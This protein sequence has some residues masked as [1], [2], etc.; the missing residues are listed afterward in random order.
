MQILNNIILISPVC[1]C[2]VVPSLPSP[3]VEGASN[4]EDEYEEPCR[5]YI[6]IIFISF[7]RFM[8]MCITDR[9]LDFEFSQSCKYMQLNQRVHLADP[10]TSRGPVRQKC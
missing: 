9:H 1:F 3:K 6:H 8:S 4:E 2:R 5:F 7:I 10:R